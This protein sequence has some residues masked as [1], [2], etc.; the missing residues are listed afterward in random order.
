MYN[1]I[2][3]AGDG[4]RF[5]NY[6]LPKPLLKVKKKTLIF[7]AAKS[8][9]SNNH[10]IFICKKKHFDNFKEFKLNIKKNFK[11]AQFI[12]LNKTTKGQAT[13][14]LRAKDLVKKDKPIMVTST[15]FCFSYDRLLLRE[16]IRKNLNIIFVCTPTNEMKKYSNQ[17]GWVRSDKDNNVTKISCKKK[18]RGY[19][20]NDNVILGAFVFSSFSYFLKGYAKMVKKKQMVNN[21]YYLDLLMNEIN[22]NKKVKIIKVKKSINWGTPQEYEKNKYKIL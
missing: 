14:L 11:N 5:K 8:L 2:L 18:F 20:K 6:K 15:D 9:P 1:I 16:Y 7:R 10:F 22:I 21:E 17:F 13:T 12:L 3:A 4:K 19:S